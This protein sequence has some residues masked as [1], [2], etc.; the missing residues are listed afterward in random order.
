MLKDSEKISEL[1]IEI[2]GYLDTHPNAADSLEGVTKWWLNP[3]KKSRSEADVLSALDYLCKMKV[4]I[5]I[6]SQ[7]GTAVYSKSSG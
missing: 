6:Q 2:S 5:K 1:A 3:S 4:V 7:F